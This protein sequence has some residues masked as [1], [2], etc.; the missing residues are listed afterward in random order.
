MDAAAR[1]LVAVHSSDPIT[2]YLA[3]RARVPGLTVA[4]LDAALYDR[5][6]L[7]RMHAMRRTLFVV[8]GNEAAV[9]DAAAGRD[10]ARAERRRLEGW[11][12]VALAVEDARPWLADLEARTL[13]ALA[14]GTPRRTQELT[15]VVEGLSQSITVGSGKW[16]AAT[17]LSSR[18]LF[19]LAMERRIVR[20]R[21]A[22]T[23]LSSQ[24]HWA[25]A[26]R[27]FAG[28]SVDVEAVVDPRVAR[29][30]LAE[31]YLRTHGPAT[32]TDL[33]WWTGWTVRA[34]REALSDAAAVEVDIDDGTPAFVL[35]DDF[36]EPAAAASQ[37]A[38]LPGL[39][40]TTMGWKQ[41]GWYLGEHGPR[42]FDRNGNAGPTIWL[43]GRVIGGW[44]QRQD[45]EVAV[46]LLEDVGKG[47]AQ[48]VR[49]AA[50]SLTDWF[51]DVVA[52]PRFRTPL[53]QQLSR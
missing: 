24:Y 17:P 19:V 34:T 18:L 31:S 1:A 45:G 30:R 47:A 36:D 53:E 15:A 20:S 35:P 10:V 40:P 48:Q 46:A 38:L 50:A 4:D 6:S 42:V 25:D 43:D 28:A 3:M 29:A 33:K 44:A 12:A 14:D 39:D 27:W 41:R 13:H 5:R 7:W 22:G 51:G 37:V 52:T 8:P 32:A 11:V 21:P 2:P 16:T 23:W 26:G 9:M 49:Q